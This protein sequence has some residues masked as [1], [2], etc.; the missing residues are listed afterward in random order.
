MNDETRYWAYIGLLSLFLLI[1]VLTIL[2]FQYV[3]DTENIPFYLVFFVEYHTLFMFMVAFIAMIF[4]GVTQIMATKRKEHDHQRMEVLQKYFLKTL[5]SNERRIIDYLFKNHGIAHQYELTK[6]Q[7]MN[8][9]KV[10]RELA[11]MERK[12]LVVRT[13]VG[14]VNKVF[15]P[16]DLKK[17]FSD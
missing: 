6:L 14:K 17:T 1:L 15:L 10:S 4:G 8:K 9:L 3:G 13:R 5:N 12:G 7:D 2:S 11:E 16:D